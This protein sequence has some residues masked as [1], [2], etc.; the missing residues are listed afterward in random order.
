MSGWR[1]ERFETFSDQFSRHFRRF[2][3]PGE[4]EQA[5]GDG[6]KEIKETV[7]GPG[8]KYGNLRTFSKISATA[9]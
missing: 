9:Q 6:V 3:V 5:T 8:P 7:T 2:K 4:R 1:A